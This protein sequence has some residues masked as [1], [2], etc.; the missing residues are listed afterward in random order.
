LTAPLPPSSSTACMNSPTVPARA[1]EP[2]VTPTLPWR[3][4]QPDEGCREPAH[5]L[6]PRRGPPSFAERSSALLLGQGGVQV[7]Q[8]RLDAGAEIG[9]QK[10]RLMRHEAAD[11]VHIAR[12]AVRASRRQAGT[13]FR[14]LRVRVRAQFRPR[15]PLGR[16][17]RWLQR[18]E[19]WH[20]IASVPSISR[21][22]GRSA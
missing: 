4:R 7:Q 9:D 16:R 10:R 15:G 19:D 11:E 18:T 2:S 8:E 17:F 6:W 20:A 1:F 14:P 3:G 13:P 12:E 22:I 5:A 21:L